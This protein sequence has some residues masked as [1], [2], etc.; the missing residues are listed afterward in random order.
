M[1][2]RLTRIPT[3]V[4]EEI[5]FYVYA[6]VNP[7]TGRIGYVGKGKGQRALAHL[8]R[9][10][11][12]RVDLLAHGIEH[13]ATAFLIEAAVIDALGLTG[14]TNRVR[15]RRAV[16]LGRSPLTEVITRYAAVPASI[17]HSCLLI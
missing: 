12:H 3:K 11:G 15:G 16:L 8:L 13:E 6:Y 10:R 1:P 5:G 2:T 17:I 7:S 4:V 14:L 9:L